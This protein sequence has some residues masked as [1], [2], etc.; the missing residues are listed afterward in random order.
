MTQC[1]ACLMIILASV[2]TIPVLSKTY[3]T[4]VLIFSL[5]ASLECGLHLLINWKG[6]GGQEFIL[7]CIWMAF[8][9][10]QVVYISIIWSTL[11]RG[12]VGGKEELA[13]DY[14]VELETNGKTQ[15]NFD[16]YGQN[17]LPP[18]GQVNGFVV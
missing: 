9:L 3:M 18:I 17:S 14:V 10:L 7:N 6:F 2:T 1:A 13:N 11:P 8:R 4:G 12:T 5:I 16:L 15:S